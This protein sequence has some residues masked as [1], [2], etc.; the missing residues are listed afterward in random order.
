M[1]D[2]HEDLLRACTVR[3]T[4]GP[5]TGAGFFVAPGKVLTCV[6]VIGDSPT[7]VVQWER[8]GQSALEIPV[9]GRVA[10]LADQGR[11]IPALEC[12]YP[13][14]AVLEI[15]GLEG[16]PCVRIDPEWPSQEDSF[17][18]FGYPKEGGAVQLSPA[19]L[20]YRGTRGTLPTAYL[21]LASDTIK[22]GMSGAA[23]LNLRSGAVCGVLVASKHTA[24]PEGA[25]AI[26]WSAIDADLGDVLAANRAFHL[27]DRRWEAALA[28]R[29]ER[30]RFRLPQVVAHF[31]G[32]EEL[33]AQLN[34][35]LIESR[36]GVI[37]QTISGLGGIGKT[38]LAAAYVAAHQDEFDIVAWVRADD[39]GIA[40]LADLAV[41]LDLRVTGRT[42]PE[43]ANDVLVFLANTQRRWLLVLDNVPEPRALASLPSSGHGRVLVTS[44]HRGGYDTFGQELAVDVFNPNT[45]RRYLLARS[46]RTGQETGDA[47]AVAAAL[48]YLPL[49]LSHAGAQCVAGAGVSFREYL[50]LLE[51]LPSQ[52]MFDSNP[53]IFYQHTIAVTW[54]ASINTAEQQAPLA[55]RAL[56]MTA[57]LAPE[58][59]PRPFFSVLDNNSAAGR[60]GVADALAALHRYSL[61]TVTGNQVS[62]HRLLQKVIRDRLNRHEQADAATHAL[63]AIQRAIPEDPRLPTMWPQ[64]QAL[65]P[66]VLAVA[67]NENVGPLEAARLADTID[68][69]C[70]FLLAAG[71]PRQ[72]QDLA[73]RAFDI[74]TTYLGTDQLKTLNAQA[75][76]AVSYWM[77]GLHAEAAAAGEQVVTGFE[78]RLGADHAQTRSAR[79]NLA[80]VYLSLGRTSE[81]VATFEL[82]VADRER[83]LGPDHPDTLRARSNLG[84]SYQLAGRTSEAI[85]IKEQVAADRERILGPDHP[86]T[87]KARGNLALS[88]QSAGRTSE[89][90]AIRRQVA[91]GR[92][93]VLGLDHPDTL[94]AWADLAESYMLAGRTGEAI[95]IQERVAADSE[96]IL[97]PDHPDTLKARDNLATAKTTAKTKNEPPWD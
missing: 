12:D 43:R 22:P 48:G 33:L 39:G 95:A 14:I 61:A 55:G 35:V 15:N 8:D 20:T 7:L 59:I 79:S 38:Q 34:T 57:F 11:P 91:A 81:A 24:H 64:W 71:F 45:A 90:I 82:V 66:H 51:G 96:R 69:M 28:T 6:H 40:D 50:E 76:L 16:H 73:T 13:D 77:S 10:V 75:N 30:L 63:T 86:D 41:A 17:Q 19:K 54:N 94:R 25:L 62:V 1:A 18:V 84:A 70:S 37:T 56:Q 4:G 60:K 31:T 83:I 3:I 9:T 80:T 88:Y 44:R 2:R 26:P 49:A 53:E 85:A 29:R 47:D 42:P 46:G 72:A 74:C 89:A 32:R 65:L 52:T 36:A 5:M 68:P 58:A 23:V 93:Q 78:R 97:G 21:E 92:E 67:S 27:Q 87:L